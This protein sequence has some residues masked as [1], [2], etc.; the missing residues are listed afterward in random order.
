MVV[1]CQPSLLGPLPLGLQDQIFPLCLLKK[2]PTLLFLGSDLVDEVESGL[3][4]AHSCSNILK[5]LSQV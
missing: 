4:F 5:G 1:L 3:P 2:L